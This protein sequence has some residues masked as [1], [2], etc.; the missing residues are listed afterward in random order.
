MANGAQCAVYVSIV[1]WIA[2]ETVIKSTP[3]LNLTLFCSAVPSCSCLYHIY[4]F[5]MW[6]QRSILLFCVHSCYA[7]LCTHLN[8][9]LNVLQTLKQL[10]RQQPPFKEPTWQLFYTIQQIQCNC[11]CLSFV[12]QTTALRCSIWLFL[13]FFFFFFFCSAKSFSHLASGQRE[14]NV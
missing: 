9:I 5:C 14:R 13:A 7:M 6:A 10:L 4:F 11:M 1:V 3:F 8:W 12:R 2:L